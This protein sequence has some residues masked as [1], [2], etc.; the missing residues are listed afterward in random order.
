[1]SRR[2]RKNRDFARQ[3]ELGLP[4]FGMMTTKATAD[5]LTQ[6][7]ERGEVTA[8][9]LEAA[10]GELQLPD[11]DPD[12][13]F[14]LTIHD[15]ASKLRFNQLGDQ[16]R[17]IILE[18]AQHS[19]TVEKFISERAKQTN[20]PYFPARLSHFFVSLYR[21]FFRE[22]GIYGDELFEAIGQAAS[23]SVKSAQRKTATKAILVHLFLICDVFERPM[24][25]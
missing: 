18:F 11:T 21:K 12:T 1:M 3:M 9:S 16:T 19:A 20:D 23:H 4:L 15:T 17:N 6:D 22:D 7:V 5:N 24:E 2:G 25:A 14:D 13:G 10:I 8:A